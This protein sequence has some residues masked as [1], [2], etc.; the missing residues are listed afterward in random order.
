MF[1][2]KKDPADIECNGNPKSS[3]GK[4]DDEKVH[5]PDAQPDA[6]GTENTEGKLL[7]ETHETKSSTA[8]TRVVQ[9]L[10][11]LLLFFLYRF[12]SEG[13]PVEK[14]SAEESIGES[15]RPS[16]GLEL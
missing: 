9:V 6:V 13:P 11:L 14:S 8:F 15:I 5:K 12:L 4:S 2:N 7:E 16:P 1:S 10:L 3:K